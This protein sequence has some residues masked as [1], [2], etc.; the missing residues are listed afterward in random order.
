MSQ[1]LIDR[2]NSLSVQPFITHVPR[3][4]IDQENVW[5]RKA[6]MECRKLMGYCM[7]YIDHD[8]QP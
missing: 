4:P 3:Q 8:L 5:Q 7:R 1:E 6:E 2:F